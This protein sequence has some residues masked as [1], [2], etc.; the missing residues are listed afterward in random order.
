[1]SYHRGVRAALLAVLLIAP[2]CDRIFGLQR[3]GEPVDAAGDGAGTD[4][5]TGR[6]QLIYMTNNADGSPQVVSGPHPDGMLSIRNTENEM[7]GVTIAPDGTFSF[8]RAPGAPYRLTQVSAIDGSV[9]VEVQLDAPRLD[10]VTTLAGRPDRVPVTMPTLLKFNPAVLG[11]EHIIASTGLWTESTIGNGDTLDWSTAGTASGVRGLL[12]A[13]KHDRIWYLNRNLFADGAATPYHA[14]DALAS[15]EI[16][17]VDGAQHS[18]TIAPTTQ[19]TRDRCARVVAKRSQALQRAIAAAQTNITL[20]I[21]DWILQ[22]VPAIDVGPVGPITVAFHSEVTTTPTDVDVVVQYANPFP[23]HEV[24]GSVGALAQRPLSHPAAV[25]PIPL[26][27]GERTYVRAQPCPATTTV[28]PFQGY[29]GTMSIDDVQIGASDGA[30]LLVQPN[31]RPTLSWTLLA[32]GPV[33]LTYVTVYR[34]EA[35]G[36]TTVLTPLKRYITTTRSASL[37]TDILGPGDYF[38]L[39]LDAVVG[40]PAAA[41]GDFSVTSYPFSNATQWSRMFLVASP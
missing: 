31:R 1:M 2:G 41:Q 29:P 18:V 8:K 11:G 5:V 24:L 12:D 6:W 39:R 36:G 38:V 4:T 21:D 33:D 37:D 40:F 32:A 7:V 30:T 9:P 22:A 14:F 17:I 23:G 34:V 13:A 3:D 10:L 16:S 35:P 28:E 15:T 19:T 26:P 20:Q 27:F 25:A